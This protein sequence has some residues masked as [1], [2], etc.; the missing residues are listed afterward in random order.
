MHLHRDSNARRAEP[1]GSVRDS[2]RHRGPRVE[3]SSRKVAHVTVV[4]GAGDTRIVHKECRSLLE[5]GYA[6]VLIV[7]GPARSVEPG[8]RVRSLK[9]PSSRLRRLTTTSV[10]ALAVALREDADLYHLH[11]P[12]LI[13]LGVA[14]KAV[15]KRVIYDSH[16]HLPRQ[17]MN[18]DWIPPILRVPVAY[19]ANLLERVAD[20]TFDGIIVANPSTVHRFAARHTALV[21]NFARVSVSD[22][23]PPLSERPV[24]VVYLGNLGRHR[25][26]W[27]MIDATRLLNRAHEKVVLAGPLDP[28]I[29]EATLVGV[30]DSLSFP[31][32]LSR[33]DADALLRSARVGLAV[34]QPVPNFTEGHYPTKLFEYMAAGLPVIASDFPLYREVVV[35]AQCGLLVDPTDAREIAS[36]MAYLLDRPDEAEAMGARGRAAVL[37]RYTWPV[38]ESALLRLYDSVLLHEPQV[39]IGRQSA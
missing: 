4:H 13:P 30:P 19:A 32:Q 8:L 28:G 18:K 10:R 34:L 12:E 5:A 14:L 9:D 31:G 6:V 7:P 27:Q 23:V 26:L 17:V 21:E 33:P 35:A 16:E 38:A 36:A 20:R 37:E 22:E 2:L 39:V 1:T 24:A 25:G 29:N 3:A 11:D 15:G